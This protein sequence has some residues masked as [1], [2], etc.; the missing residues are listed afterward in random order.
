[1]HCT[2]A[3]LRRFAEKGAAVITSPPHTSHIFQVLDVFLFGRLKA[4]KK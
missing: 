2:E 4:A 3:I 1:M